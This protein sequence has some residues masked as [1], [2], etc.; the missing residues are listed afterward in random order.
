MRKASNGAL[1]CDTD[2]SERGSKPGIIFHLIDL[3]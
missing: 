2:L 1:H 3:Q